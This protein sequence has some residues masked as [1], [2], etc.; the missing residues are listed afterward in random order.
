MLQKGTEQ[1]KEAQELSNR[2]Q[3]I[4]NYERWNNNNSY[5]LHFNPFYRF[6]NEIIKLNV[7]ASNVA[8]TIDEKCTYPSFKIANMSS[9]QAWILAC[10]AIENNINLKIVTLLYGLDD[11]NKN[12]LYME[13]KRT[14]VLSFHV[15]RGGRFFN[16]G[17]VE[18]VGEKTFSDV[19]SMLSD[20]LFTKNRDE[21]GR[22]CKPYI[23]DEV[24]TVVSEDDENGRTGEIDFDGDY[25]RYYTIEIEDIDDLSDSELEAIREY[26]GYISEDLERL[27]KVSDDEE[28]E[29]DEE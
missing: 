16:P 9:K 18:F 21:H 23:A 27:I 17:H 6:L 26:K 5:E 7:F 22:F 3:Q 8:K 28:N 14:M 2:L 19:C 15:C 10:A 12:Y 13:T 24:G 11:L 25:D 29:E 20:R 1:Y 4:A